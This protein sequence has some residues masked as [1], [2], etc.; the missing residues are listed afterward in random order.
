M[1]SG[2]RRGRNTR[3]RVNCSDGVNGLMGFL[4]ANHPPSGDHGQ[5]LIAEKQ[6]VAHGV[7]NGRV[8]HGMAKVFEDARLVVGMHDLSPSVTHHLRRWEPE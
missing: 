1:L 4:I 8:E 2:Y 6:A 3:E 7:G 5:D